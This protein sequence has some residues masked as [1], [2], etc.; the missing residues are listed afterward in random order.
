MIEK[1]EDNFEKHG[2]WFEEAQEVVLNPLSMVAENNHSS[3][4]RFEYLG[5]SAK[6]KLL[7]VVTAE[8]DELEI[9][10]ISARKATSRERQ[11]YEE[12]I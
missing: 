3:G 8:R 2:V 5:F 1:N 7:Y 10:V 4:E 6:M 12:G 9:R 11:K